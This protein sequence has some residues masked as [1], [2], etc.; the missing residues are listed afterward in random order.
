[1]GRGVAPASSRRW[2][3]TVP[4]VHTPTSHR[5][6]KPRADALQGLDLP[7]PG[8]ECDNGGATQLYRYVTENHQRLSLYALCG[9]V[10]RLHQANLVDTQVSNL[11]RIKL[12]D[13]LDNVTSPV[14]M[15]R[16]LYLLHKCPSM[17]HDFFVMIANRIYR[18]RLYPSGDHP[19]LWCRYF[20]FIGD[21]R[22]YHKALLEVLCKGFTSYIG[23]YLEPP[24]ATYT[25]RM[26]ES[27]AIAS[28][29]LAITAADVE[30]GDL[31]ACMLR[32]ATI[33]GID[34]SVTIRIYWSAAVRR[35]GLHLLDLALVERL[36]EETLSDPSVGLRRKSH[37]H[38]IYTI[39][40]CL[41]LADIDVRG[42][43]ARC[44]DALNELRYGHNDSKISTSQRYVSDVLVRLGVPHKV[45]LLTPELLSIDIAIEGDGERIALEVDGPLHFTR[46]CDGSEASVPMRTGPTQA[47]QAFL[48]SQGWLVLS[49]PPVKLDDSVD[50]TT[51]IASI[52]AYYK[53]LLVGSGSPYLNRLLN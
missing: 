53:R 13:N 36:L 45:E 27:V 2:L 29:A 1:M 30:L 24:R 47:K 21:N 40:R 3:G 33:P 6:L 51:A 15:G 34:R 35:E 28:W 39:L 5:S 18:N 14:V 52:D 12:V 32:F 17:D 50:L 4:E 38:Q 20:K 42:L 26:Q 19:R 11:L 46:V 8:H 31:F 22:L 16:V 7:R 9:H 25:R 44:L 48:K 41:E 37:L 43:N 10:E 23:S 49:V